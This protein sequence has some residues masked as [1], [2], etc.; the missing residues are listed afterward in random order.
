MYSPQNEKA[1][2]ERRDKESIVSGGLNKLQKSP[3]SEYNSDRLESML[4]T[5]KI[6]VCITKA[7]SEPALELACRKVPWGSHWS[8]LRVRG[9]SPVTRRKDLLL[10]HQI[11]LSV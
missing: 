3:N 10:T 9:A 2:T 11:Q 7:A 6:C 1:N 5:L 8:N 4:A